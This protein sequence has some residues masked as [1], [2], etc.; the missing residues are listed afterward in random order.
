MYLFK[1][2]IFAL[3]ALIIAAQ[4]GACSWMGE[5]AGRAKAGTENAI[6][7]TREGYHKGYEEGKKK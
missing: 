2:S 6:E 4:A 7:D 3:L 5:T 1:R